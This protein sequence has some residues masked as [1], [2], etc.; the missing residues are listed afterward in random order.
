VRVAALDA[1]SHR[2]DPSVLPSIDPKMDDENDVVK[3]TAAA[4]VIHLNDI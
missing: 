3:Y 1:L 4:A 2:G